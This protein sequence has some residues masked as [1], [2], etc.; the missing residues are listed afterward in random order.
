MAARGFLG[1]G[2]LYIARFVNGAPLP[3]EG[4]YECSK[5]EIKP[6][7]NLVEM[8]SKGRSTY[9][10][11]IESVTIPQPADLT[12]DL[13]EVNKESLAIALLGTTAAVSQTAGTIT[14]E[15][16][17]IAAFDRWYPLS[18]AFFA[19]ITAQDSTNTSLVEGEDFIVDKQLGWI[20]VLPGSTRVT[21][22]EVIKVSGSYQA[23][24]GNEIK[25]MTSPQL[26]ARFLLVGKN[27]A[28]DLPYRV[29]VYEAIIAADS[30]FDFLQDN[31]ASISLPGRMKTPTGFTEPASVVQMTSVG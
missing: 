30:A 2:D 22:N 23:T 21:V 31:F 9:G 20:K 18:K 5:F 19:T 28:D 6:N 4:P 11:V 17:T 10:Q 26:R 3:Y 27:F 8:T 7:V 25:A 1:S 29:T 14:N 16:V 24:T 15:N 13:P 12:V